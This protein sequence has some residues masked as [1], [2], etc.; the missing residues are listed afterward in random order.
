MCNC[1][2]FSLFYFEFEETSS[3]GRFSTALSSDKIVTDNSQQLKAVKEGANLV[4]LLSKNLLVSLCRQ[5]TPIL[6]LQFPVF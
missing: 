5:Q 6:L 1:T 3:P 4:Y 2:A